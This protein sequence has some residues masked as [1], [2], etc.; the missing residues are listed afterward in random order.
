[1]ARLKGCGKSDL[2][3]VAYAGGVALLVAQAAAS[4][5]WAQTAPL[6]TGPLPSQQP[7][8]QPEFRKPPP[9]QLKLP[10]VT[11]PAGERLP[12]LR[13]LVHKFRIT[14]NTVFPTAELEKI[15]APF[16]NREISSTD[17]EEL[18]QRLTL[19]YVNHGYINSGAVIPDQKVT[20][21]VIEIHIVEGRLTETDISGTK[22]FNKSYFTD[23]IALHAG[24][25]LNI[26][27]LEQEL[28][29]LL[30]DPMVKSMN[31][32]LVPGAQPGEAVLK[33][34][35]EEAPR[36]DIGLVIDNKLS[37]SLGEVKGTLQGSVNN[38]I[39]R[40]DQLGGEFGYA[41]GI[42]YDYKL[43]YRTPINAHDTAVGVH[44]EKT[45]AQVVES[46]FD[47]LDIKSKLESYGGE[48]SQ[49]VYRTPDQQLTLAGVLERRHTSTTL[50][51]VPFSFS[52]G[53]VDGNAT[54]SVARFVGDYVDRGR[55]QVIAARSTLSVG[56][57]AFGST[58]HS[59][60]PDS[61]F[62]AWLGQFQWVTR[63]SE[64]G[65][66]LLLRGDLQVTNDSLLPVEQYAVGGLDS[67]RGYRT[68][69]LL[70]DQGYTAS[71]EYRI[72]VFKNPTDAR[73]LM[74]AA[75]VDTGGASFKNK[76]QSTSGPSQLTG[77]GVGLIWAPAAGYSAELYYAKGIDSVP[78]PPSY[79]IQDES[80]YFRLIAHPGWLN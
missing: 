3:G 78:N 48:V 21:D 57:D 72:P 31:A 70:R 28:Q 64:R 47:A 52:P 12:A 33:A 18:R 26:R 32:Q 44:Y 45:K 5:A 2:A 7:L 79:S 54:V 27:N 1:V 15:A 63:L 75:Y 22:H 17:L 30:R 67:V 80:L 8:P 41:D 43:N 50:L 55:T 66:Q 11:P 71:I 9:E 14:G 61:R 73:N 29:I 74:F 10:P 60:A 23:R 56:L 46:P 4:V 65:D 34:K 37:P 42:P 36:Y 51:G 19:Y 62:V 76:D 39:G 13:V 40:G 35:V 16:E 53:V 68:Y 58:I 24:P 38:L 69:Q 25:P 77:V 6:P 20:G 59:D 49:P